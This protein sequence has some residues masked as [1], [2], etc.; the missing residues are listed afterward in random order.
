M[1]PHTNTQTNKQ[2]NK[3]VHYTH[4]LKVNGMFI[5]AGSID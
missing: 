4:K 1:H 3:Q 5:Q 2:T